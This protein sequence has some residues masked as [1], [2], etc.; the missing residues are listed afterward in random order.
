MITYL[1]LFGLF[2]P[3]FSWEEESKVTSH[4]HSFKFSLTLTVTFQEESPLGIRT[5]RSTE[6]KLQRK[7][8]KVPLMWVAESDGGQGHSYFHPQVLRPIY[9]TQQ[10]WVKMYWVNISY[11][12]GYH[13]SPKGINHKLIFQLL[14][15]RNQSPNHIRPAISCW[16][17]VK[18]TSGFHEPMTTIMALWHRLGPLIQGNACGSCQFSR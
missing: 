17:G 8:A 6:P 3:A 12:E 13:P 10:S 9:S 7:E 15:S 4:S 18:Q 5:Y 16:H 2:L 11:P 14:P 1:P